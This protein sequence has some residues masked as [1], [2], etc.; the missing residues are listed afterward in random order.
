MLRAIRSSR[1]NY[2]STEKFIGFCDDNTSSDFGV[3]IRGKAY[4][5]AKLKDR[6]KRGVDAVNFG[7][8]IKCM[9]VGSSYDTLPTDV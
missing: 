7:A 8:L 5:I 4:I 3:A 1:R 2:K 9:C 6:K